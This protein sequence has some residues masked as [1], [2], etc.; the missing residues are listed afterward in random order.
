LQFAVTGVMTPF[1]KEAA[2]LQDFFF[3]LPCSQWS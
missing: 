2:T 3:A 1:D